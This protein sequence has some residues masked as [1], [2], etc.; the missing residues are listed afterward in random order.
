MKDSLTELWSKHDEDRPVFALAAIITLN[1][2]CN[3][4]W[5]KET[6]TSGG[7]FQYYNQVVA[8]GLNRFILGPG[9]VQ[10]TEFYNCY[11]LIPLCW[12][13]SRKMEESAR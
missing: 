9:L 6:N 2:S 1:H 3:T 4:D 13:P 7:E 11:L 12:I 8:F 10:V 5:G